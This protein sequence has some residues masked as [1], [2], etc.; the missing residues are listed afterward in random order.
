M[1]RNVLKILAL[2]TIAL[3]ISH[4]EP[5]SRSIEATGGA[6]PL[7]QTTADLS[8]LK[9]NTLYE[10]ATG[11]LSNGAGQH[12]FSGKTD[13]SALLR[14][15]LIT[16]DI[17]GSIPAG[18]TI[19]SVTLTLNMSKTSSGTQTIELHRLLADWGEGSSDAPSNEGGG[20][21]AATRRCDMA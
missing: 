9:D 13:S 11:A 5:R 17:A 18:S 4:V 1:Q 19:E 7:A 14:R 16:F 2:A 20:T 3:G 15:G 12:F 8:P 21:S 10:S 6:A